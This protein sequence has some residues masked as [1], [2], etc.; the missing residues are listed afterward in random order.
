MKTLVAAALAALLLSACQKPVHH[1]PPARLTVG[2]GAMT[3]EQLAAWSE[4]APGAA[5]FGAFTNALAGVTNGDEILTRYAV[6]MDQQIVEYLAR[7]SRP[8]L[9]NKLATL[10]RGTARH[11][12]TRDQ[13]E[14]ALAL[15]D[16][17]AHERAARKVLR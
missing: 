1:Q 11:G 9:S 5:V 6:A 14:A 2:T 4:A 12:Y 17:R 3:V 7:Q 13:L 8:A 15:K 16:E 10:E